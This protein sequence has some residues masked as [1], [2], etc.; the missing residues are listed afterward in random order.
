M[1]VEFGQWLDEHEDAILNIHVALR[2]ERGDS[3]PVQEIYHTT[4][5]GSTM[6][7][8]GLR[9]EG[10]WGG[11][12]DVARYLLATGL[13]VGLLAESSLLLYTSIRRVLDDEQPESRVEWLGDMGEK[14]LTMNQAM[15]RTLADTL[16]GQKGK[17]E[18]LYEISRGISAATDEQALLRVLGQPAID[19]GATVIDLFYFDLDDD[20]E[21]EWMEKIATG[22]GEGKSPVGTR[23][24]LPEFPVARLYL[25][26]PHEPRLVADVTLDERIDEN[27][28][29]LLAQVGTRAMVFVPLTDTGNWVGVIAFQWNEAHEFS[30][31]EVEIYNALISLATPAVKMRRMVGNLEQMVAERAAEL[32]ASVEESE[33]LQMEII[34]EVVEAQRQALQELS[35]PIIPVMERILVMPL[36]GSIDSMRA[37]DIT[38]ALLAGIREHRAQIVILDI[39][40]V[41]LVDSGVASHLNKT[42]QAARLKGAHTIVTG[43]SDAVAETIVDLGI[44]WSSIDT[45]NDLQ[46][47][48]RVALN[49]VGLEL[50]PIRSR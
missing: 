10:D 3:R 38:R 22:P 33:R 25:D 32:Q 20:G 39:T 24:Y 40:G 19:A 46:T 43:V 6:M 31:H 11:G 7:I 36:I 34:Q 23:Y 14:L 12:E 13:P 49:I 45:L 44:D 17:I 1:S 50:T 5:A 41:P 42:I 26:N 18:T 37:R 35:T 4:K 27:T 9:G 16:E 48:L 8:M 29:L 2:Q 15:T 47:G 30:Q 28:K 21:P